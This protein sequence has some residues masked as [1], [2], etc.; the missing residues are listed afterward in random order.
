MIKTKRRVHGRLVEA[1]ARAILG[2]EVKPGESLEGL[3][4][5][6]ALRRVSHGAMREAFRVLAAKGLIQAAPRIGTRVRSREHWD[7]LDPEL[8]SWGHGSEAY[9]DFV[10]SVEEARL[11][12]EPA[13]ARLAASR[14]NGGDISRLESAYDD[15]ASARTPTDPLSLAADLRFHQTILCASGNI[16]FARIAALLGPALRT[17]FYDTHAWVA[18]SAAMDQHRIVLE[19]IRL[20]DGARAHAGM[21]SLLA[22]LAASASA[23]SRTGSARPEDGSLAIPGQAIRPI[24]KGEIDG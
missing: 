19:A 7:L 20:R 13:A 4:M 9:R 2:G 17:V 18:R 15:M 8:I 22:P 5:P 11:S 6:V 14:A 1:L 24:S 3:S 23:S 16:V 12:I 10:S 21:E